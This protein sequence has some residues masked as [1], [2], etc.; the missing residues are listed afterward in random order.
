M[1]T[2]SSQP[3]FKSQARVASGRRGADNPNIASRRATSDLANLG[4]KATDDDSGLIVLGKQLEEAIAKIRALYDPAS[5]DHLERI[6]TM[7]ASL[8]PVEQAI[9]A[10]PARTIAGL[11]VKARHA[12]YV[13]SE[14]WDAPI[15]Q[16]DWDARAVRSLIEAVYDVASM[17]SKEKR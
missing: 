5:P 8:L 12:A 2:P 6:E 3:S 13:I 1:K 17:N 14:H 10:T 4:F 7:L 11:G 15:D 9:I 16:I